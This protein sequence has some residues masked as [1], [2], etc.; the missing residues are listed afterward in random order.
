MITPDENAVRTAYQALP[1]T[2]EC[3]N[4]TP[5]LGLRWHSLSESILDVRILAARLRREQLS[6]RDAW[7]LMSSR[8]N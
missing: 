1:K 7:K 2:Y 5:G 3:L 6:N 8:G 4:L